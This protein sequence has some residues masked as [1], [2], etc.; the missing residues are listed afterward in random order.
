MS[1]L[2][3]LLEDLQMLGFT[4]Y[5]A[6][7]YIAILRKNPI[8]RHQLSKLANVPTAKVYETIDRL[9][10]R[11]IVSPTN[12]T[13]RPTYV[14]LPPEEVIHQI[15]AT[16]EYKL[17]AVEAKLQ[18][19]AEQSDND[20]H[21][22]T[23]N[24][25]GTARILGKAREVIARSQEYIMCALWAQEI[26]MLMP[27]LRGAQERGVEIVLLAYG[28]A[29]DDL[30]TVHRHGM[31]ATLLEQTGGRWLALAAEAAQEVV[32]GFFPPEGTATGVWAQNPILS[33]I[34]QKYIREHFLSH[35]IDLFHLG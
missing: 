12:S 13:D 19:I 14:P 9:V 27:Y 6:R 31:E 25:E 28:D 24:L 23:W 29:P 32:I 35:G 34:T 17:Q 22:L 5:E 8:N 20:I 10:Q 26:E 7:T 15:R 1:D 4:E 33:M 3:Q 18:A 30:G 2:T 16:T 11:G 21:P